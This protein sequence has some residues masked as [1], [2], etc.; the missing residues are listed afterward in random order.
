MEGYQE[1]CI[2]LAVCLHGVIDE[3]YA[4][5][6]YN[7]NKNRLGVNNR[8]KMKKYTK[9]QILKA[10]PFLAYRAYEINWKELEGKK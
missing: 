6:A 4:G 2:I 9:E 10:F 3:S 8:A 5:T 1:R 7:C